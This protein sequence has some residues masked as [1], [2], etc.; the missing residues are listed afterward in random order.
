MLLATRRS[1]PSQT[2]PER[3]N[4]PLLHG[5][6]GGLRKFMMYSDSH[7]AQR[8]SFAHH[9]AQLLFSTERAFAG[10]AP[11]T[12]AAAHDGTPSAAARAEAFRRRIRAGLLGFIPV[13]A[14]AAG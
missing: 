2:A 11:T 9:R 13:S 7:K 1:P 12:A 4:Y 6:T 3:I 5:E 8:N 14:L 10:D